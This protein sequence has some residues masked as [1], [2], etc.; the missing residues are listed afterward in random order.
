MATKTFQVYE[1]LQKSTIDDILDELSTVGSDVTE[2][3]S[4]V[5]APSDTLTH[6]SDVSGNGH[7]IDLDEYF[8]VIHPISLLHSAPFSFA[9][10]NCTETTK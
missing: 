5:V 6:V 10:W 2:A 1:S 7:D 4:D 8:Q 3:S 9:V